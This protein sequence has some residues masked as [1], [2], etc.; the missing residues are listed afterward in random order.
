MASNAC[1]GGEHIDPFFK[2]DCRTDAK[3]SQRQHS[4]NEDTTT[5]ARIILLHSIT[6]AVRHRDYLGFSLLLPLSARLQ[7]PPAQCAGEYAG[8]LTSRCTESLLYLSGGRAGADFPAVPI[9][10][11]PV[12]IEAS[13]V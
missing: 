2:Y 1:R 9:A 13:P 8:A 12:N 11:R 7:P 4:P 5:D 3:L 10:Y 6:A